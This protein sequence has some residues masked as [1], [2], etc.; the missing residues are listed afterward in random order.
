MKKILASLLLFVFPALV[1]AHE[2]A[3]HAPGFIHG[4]GQSHGDSVHYLVLAAI[5]LVLVYL[6]RRAR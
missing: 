5:G 1:L 4:F 3:D 2:S 6:W